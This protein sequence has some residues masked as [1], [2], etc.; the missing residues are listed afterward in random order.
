MALSLSLSLT[1]PPPCADTHSRALTPHHTRT[2]T[3]LP[4]T[5]LL[6]PPLPCASWCCLIHFSAPSTH[7]LRL[8]AG[9]AGLDIYL[10]VQAT[11]YTVDLEAACSAKNHKQ[12]DSEAGSRSTN[13]HCGAFSAKRRT[14]QPFSSSRFL[15]PR[16][17]LLELRLKKKKK[18]R[19]PIRSLRSTPAFPLDRAAK[20]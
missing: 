17:V 7:R 11:S 20:T 15:I 16:T 5:Y 6:P 14:Q 4:R 10:P 12:E 9:G 18:N 3:R 19:E 2:Q 8:G 1:L 13:T